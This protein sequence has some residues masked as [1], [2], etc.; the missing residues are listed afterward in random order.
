MFALVVLLILLAFFFIILFFRI[1]DNKLLKTVT[2]RNR[3]TRSERHLV[4]QLLKNGFSAQDIFHD[5]Y[6]KKINSGFSQ[7]D[8]I[9]VTEVGI[10]VIEVKDYSGWIFGVGYNYYWTQVL[11]GGNRKYQFYN[12]I[13]QNRGHIVNLK[14]S[15]KYFENIPFYSIVVFYGDCVLKKISYVPKEVCLIKSDRVLESVR[16]ILSENKPAFYANKE[17]LISLLRNSVLNGEDEEVKFQH[18]HNMNVML[19]DQK[20]IT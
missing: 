20:S 2:R 19:R 17:E 15:N 8:L 3:G 10:I 13:L 7:I 9:L 1:Q 12:P 14:Q 18:D 5:I 4:L 6:L 16:K 11:A